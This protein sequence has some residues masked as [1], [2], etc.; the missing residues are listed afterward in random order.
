MTLKA[1][2]LTMLLAMPAFCANENDAFAQPK[3][4]ESLPASIEL[5]FNYQGKPYATREPGEPFH[6]GRPGYGSIWFKWTPT[7]DKRVVLR[8]VPSNKR[9]QMKTIIAVYTGTKLEELTPVQRSKDLPIPA[10]SRARQNPIGLGA[11]TEFDARKGV[12]YRI[13][14]DTETKLFERFS[15]K[16]EEGGA[17]FHANAELISAAT[18]WDYL[19]LVGASGRAI[20]PELLDSDF[21][22]T[23]TL[24]E[25]YDGPV[26]NKNG[27]IPIAYGDVHRYIVRTNFG[28]KPGY[29]PDANRSFTS[30]LRT[31]FTPEN[32]ITGLGIEGIFDDGAVIY[33]NGKEIQRFN[34]SPDK[35][36]HRWSTLADGKTLGENSPTSTT[37]QYGIIEDLDL[38][39]GQPVHVAV[40]VHSSAKNNYDT[41]FSMRMYSLIP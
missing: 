23:W 4:I 19:F 33:V 22:K 18:R 9:S 11:R 39:G 5:S 30:Y 40:S 31:T 14:V 21:R 13:A 32:S 16:L 17:P 35:D 38:P 34:V 41:L 24:E 10:V 36:P 29:K 12:T 3:E 1:L 2:A 27:F 28:G 20:D 25:G 6:A 15:L 26:F 8:A 7:E 37:V